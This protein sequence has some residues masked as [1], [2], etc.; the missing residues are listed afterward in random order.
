VD[1]LRVLEVRGHDRLGIDEPGP[2]VAGG[3]LGVLLVPGE[4]PGAR[5]G[6]HLQR[7]AHH[8]LAVL[9]EVVG[10]LIPSRWM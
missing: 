3:V 4:Q 5:Q 8:G 2:Q 7:Q 10:L 1:R 9:D 6:R